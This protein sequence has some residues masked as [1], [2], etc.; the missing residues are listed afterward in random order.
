M[1]DNTQVTERETGH[2]GADCPTNRLVET[3]E[4]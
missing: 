2:P 1:F 4:N 3:E